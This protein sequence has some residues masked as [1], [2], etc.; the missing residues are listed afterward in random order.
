MGNVV[1]ITII[2]KMNHFRSV[3][4]DIMELTVNSEFKPGDVV[5]IIY[6]R[7]CVEQ[8]VRSVKIE[9]YL[10]GDDIATVCTGYTFSLLSF[11]NTNDGSFLPCHVYGDRDTAMRL[12]KWYP[13]NLS[14]H[15]WLA[16]LG[17]RDDSDSLDECE[18][19]S[20]CS[21][22]S[23]CRSILYDCQNYG[24]LILRD[25]ER[26]MKL[27]DD[28][29]PEFLSRSKLAENNCVNAINVF[30]QLKILRG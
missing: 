13:V 26:I 21:S 6:G 18:L 7:K 4:E 12:A 1:N 10:D 17:N 14:D 28:A 19:Q 8:I 5:W 9:A 16:F 30:G 29:H 3:F 24:G 25:V 27:L 2:V 15:E 22:I 20:C 11:S 23:K